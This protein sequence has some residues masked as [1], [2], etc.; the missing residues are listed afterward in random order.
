MTEPAFA[1]TLSAL[2]L[3]VVVAWAVATR[4]SRRILD[5]TSSNQVGIQRRV[6][7]DS[8]T[9]LSV[10]KYKGYFTPTTVLEHQDLLVRMR[11]GIRCPPNAKATPLANLARWKFTPEVLKDDQL[12]YN[13]LEAVFRKAKN[14]LASGTIAQPDYVVAVSKLGELLVTYLRPVFGRATVVLTYPLAADLNGSKRPSTILLV[15]AVINTG[16]S[17]HSAIRW[18]QDQSLETGLTIQIQGLVAVYN[19]VLIEHSPYNA[20]IQPMF[21]NDHIVAVAKVSDIQQSLLCSPE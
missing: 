10:D 11:K 15:D 2:V 16:N 6:A 14:A 8:L 21:G 18:F 5:L 13:L 17:F 1:F 20:V 3:G 4:L 12:V 19:D 9:N 7:Y